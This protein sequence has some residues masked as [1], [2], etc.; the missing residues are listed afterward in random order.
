MLLRIRRSS[1]DNSPQSKD[2]A[3]YLTVSGYPLEDPSIYQ[4]APDRAGKIRQS[5]MAIGANMSAK[6]DVA[7]NALF[8]ERL[9]GAASFNEA[10]FSM[11]IRKLG[12]KTYFTPNA[13]VHHLVGTD[14]ISQDAVANRSPMFHFIRGYNEA[15]AFF[16]LRSLSPTPKLRFFLIRFSWYYLLYAF[17][18]LYFFKNPAPV[19]Y[20][21][22]AI[23]GI[24]DGLLL[25]RTGVRP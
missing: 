2:D 12:Y 8:D 15:L 24:R 13:I 9:L 22:G 20:G 4:A 11:S 23:R 19:K 1:F 10:V 18:G 6:R 5:L 7:R 14:H 16:L 17:A 25:G 3:A 21:N